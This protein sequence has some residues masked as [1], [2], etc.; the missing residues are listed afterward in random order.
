[1]SDQSKAKIEN[2]EQRAQELTPEEA[3]QAH[4]GN[5]WAGF[6]RIAEERGIIIDYKT[7]GGPDTL[8]P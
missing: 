4:G 1:M 3:E 8:T 7:L 2:L 5:T 6:S